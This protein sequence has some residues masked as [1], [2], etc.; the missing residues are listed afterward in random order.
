MLNDAK[1]HEKTPN[2]YWQQIVWSVAR[3][4]NEFGSDRVQHVWHRPGH[5]DC[6]EVTMKNEGGR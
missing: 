6:N 2:E 3:G 5:S 1:E 4:A